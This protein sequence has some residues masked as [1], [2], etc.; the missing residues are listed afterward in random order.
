MRL[1]VSRQ[2]GDEEVA[3]TLHEYSHV[4]F[5]HWNYITLL[6]RKVSKK[7]FNVAQSQKYRRELTELLFLF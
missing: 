5:Q 6:R 1:L 4:F 3:D 2:H 7:R